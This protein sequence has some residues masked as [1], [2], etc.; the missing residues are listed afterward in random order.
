MFLKFSD[1]IR[2]ENIIDILMFEVDSNFADNIYL[3]SRLMKRSKGSGVLTQEEHGGILGHI[4]IEIVVFRILFFDY[5]RQTRRNSVLWFYDSE[6]LYD[7][8]V[9][10]FLQSLISHLIYHFH[11]LFSIFN[12]YKKRN[13][14]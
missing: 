7:S 2:T 3:N 5:V 6:T 9:H 14:I 10:N 12:Q 8:L 13:Y 1:V 11:K 4:P